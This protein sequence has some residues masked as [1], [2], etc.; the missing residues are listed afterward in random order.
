MV[1]AGVGSGWAQLA[2]PGDRILSIDRFGESG[3][4]EEVAAA[5]GIDAK[6][7]AAKVKECLQA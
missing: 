7:I 3:P 1:E 5:F 2:R 6:G 4:A